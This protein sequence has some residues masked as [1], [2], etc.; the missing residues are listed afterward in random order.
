MTET[1]RPPYIYR[2]G[3]MMMH[4]PFQQQDSQMFGFFVKGDIHKLQAM[5]DQQLNAVAR[6][7]YRFKPLTNYVMVT[8]THIGKDFS[9]APEDIDKGWGAEIDTSIWVPVGQYIEKDGEEVLDRIHWITPYIWVDQPMTVLNGREIFGYP[10]YMAKFQMPKTPRKADFFSVDVNAFQTYS[11]EEEAGFHR[12]FDVQREPCNESLLDEI[13]DDFTDAIDFAKGIFRGL[14][15]LDDVIHPDSDLIE[16]LLGGLLSPRLPQLF[17]KQFPDGSGNDAVYQALTTSPAIING[18]HGAGILPG[19]YQLT[20]QEY[21]SEP[22]AEDLGLEI[23]T[24]SAPLA[25][26]INF[27]FSIEPPEELVNN[28]VAKKQKIAVLGGGVSAMTAAF[29]I[30]SQPDWQSRYD[31]SVYQLGWRLGGKGASGRN[32]KDH[33]RIEEHGLHIW[34]GFYENAFKVMRD[35]YGELDRPKDAPLA[36]WLEAFK[37]HSFV[38]VEEYIKENWHTWAFDFPVKDGYPGDGR[39]MLSIGQIVQTMYAWL[40]KAIEDLIEQVTGLDINNDPKPRRSGFGMFLQRFLDKFDNPLEDLM[41]EGLQLIFALSKWAEIPERIFDEAEQILFHDSL[42]HLKDW[43]DD[44]IEDILEDNAEIRHLYILID[45]ALA[46]LTGMHDDKIFERGF[47]SINDMDF[48]DWLRKHG[49]NEEFTVNSAPVRAVYDLVFAYVDGDINKANFEAGT[50]LRGSLRMVFCYEGGIMWK[51]QAGMGDVVFTPLY[52]VLKNRG[53]KFN[54]FNKVEELVPDPDNPT[55]IG[56][57]KITQQV[58]LNSGPEHYHPLVN[59]KG[60]ACWPSEPLNDQI[61]E[62]QAGLLQAHNINLE[63][64]WSNWPEIYENAYGKPLPQISLKAGEDFDK[65][66][67]GLSLGSVPIVCPKLLPLSPTLQACVDN[68]KVVATQAFQVWQ[69]PSL[70]EL[71][72]KPIP[73]SG[74]E[75]VL[76]SFTEPLDT[77]ASMDQLICREVWPD[78]E[79]KPKNCSYFCGALPVPDYPPF[80][81]H[82]FP[83]VQADEVK[84]NAITLLDKH[85]HNLWPNTQARGEG[86]KWEGLIAPD[87]EQGVARFD[88]QYWRA[89][90][91]PSERYV[92]SVVNSSKYRPKTDE[93]GFSNLYVTGDWIKNGMNA[94]CVEGAVQA[95]LTTSRAICGHPEIIKGEHQFMDDNH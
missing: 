62:K 25:F 61:V 95:G 49:A 29:A 50:C 88:A 71:G 75:P 70:E 72:W 79:I 18:F 40:R 60:L 65:I 47:D 20:L 80:S 21:A 42:K 46:A 52:Q 32:A 14:R 36:T 66:I 27:D 9:T 90:V 56:E 39:E 81:D 8:F 15:E 55:Q 33:E 76:T 84:E 38:V 58:Q 43:I 16:Q 37:P 59:V 34:F 68:V 51:M 13:S 3:G 4:P 11:R 54:Y 92:Q 89:N 12:L 78:T 74:E 85:I 2:G 94:G 44:L 24:Q 10:K 63:S 30:T 7:K 28:S 64:S 45:L 5:C 26:W 48:R 77:W 87:S 6:G 22:I 73:D 1:T 69:K 53:V 35:A 86:F 19:D 23:G 93:T 67:F 91:D 83:K 17:L 57:I 82:N 41:N 31:L